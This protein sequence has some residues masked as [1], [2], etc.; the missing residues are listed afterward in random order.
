MTTRSQHPGLH[1][2]LE[3]LHQG[4]PLRPDELGELR[5]QIEELGNDA[6]PPD[7]RPHA[8]APVPD[9]PAPSD[10]DPG[11]AVPGSAISGSAISGSA[12]SG[13][14]TAAGTSR[15]AGRAAASTSSFHCPAQRLSLSGI[16]IGTSRGTMD[17]RTDA[18]YADAVQAA[19]TAGVNVLDTAINYR[20]QRSERSVGDGLRRFIA[21]CGGARDEVVVCT[22]GGYLVPGAVTPGTLR[23][24]EVVDGHAMAPAFLTDQIERSRR[25]LGLAT[26]DVYYLHNPE[27]QLAVL[28]ADDFRDRLRAAFEALEQAVAHGAIRYYGTATWHGYRDGS[29]SLPALVEVA[30]EVAGDRH[31]FRFVQLPVNFGMLE[32]LTGPPGGG[33][34]VLAAA[35][36]A[37]ITVVASAALLGA[38]LAR[39]LPGRLADLVPGLV[40]D[41]QRSLQFVRSTPGIAT[42]LVGMRSPAHVAENLAVA[43]VPPL[44]T[45]AFQALLAALG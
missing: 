6:R 20:H 43:R 28:G 25:N 40:T 45:D 18:A 1:A 36:D 17:G 22:K 39:G 42:A 41:A 9:T 4:E 10:L 32:A 15:F 30:R 21:G 26:I 31:H 33:Q 11:S 29:L 19:L 2:L 8:A 23:R 3:K 37:G 7:G 16:G 38:R 5:R 35:A 14:A 34:G 27:T 44:P 12:I 24:S 13:Y